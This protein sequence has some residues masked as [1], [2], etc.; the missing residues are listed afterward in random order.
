MITG[1]NEVPGTRFVPSVP[2]RS[3]GGNANMLAGTSPR[4]PAQ[5]NGG[6]AMP[7]DSAASVADWSRAGYIFPSVSSASR[8]CASVRLVLLGYFWM[9]SRYAASASLIFP[10]SRYA[11]PA[12]TRYRALR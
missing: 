2:N 12:S 6:A 7:D 5:R 11:R 3:V 8:T 9:T 1:S 10:A 4:H